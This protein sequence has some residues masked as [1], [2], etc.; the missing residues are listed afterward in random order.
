MIHTK[1]GWLLVLL[2]VGM[3]Q[4]AFAQI[5][6]KSL[7]VELNNP[8]NQKTELVF[9]LSETPKY[10]TQGETLV[11]KSSSFKGEAELANVKQ[12]TF[13]NAVPTVSVTEN[14]SDPIS[15]FPNPTT[16]MIFVRG[17]SGTQSVTLTAVSG[18]TLNILAGGNDG[19]VS[20]NVSG[21]APAT[22]ILS[23]DGQTFKF[24]KK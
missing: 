18:R 24:I 4:L 5:S 8:V 21:L 19:M 3:T 14:L 22:Y 16:E 12:I 10:W 13:S 17:I 23:V 20:I 11:I 6:V 1:K 15:V 7:I 9:A 2:M